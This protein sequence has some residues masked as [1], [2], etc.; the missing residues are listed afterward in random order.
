MKGYA[1]KTFLGYIV[2]HGWNNGT[3]VTLHTWDD[4][5]A[6]DVDDIIACALALSDDFSIDECLWVHSSDD[7]LVARIDILRGIPADLYGGPEAVVR[8]RAWE[9]GRCF[10]TGVAVIINE[11]EAYDTFDECGRCDGSGLVDNADDS[12]F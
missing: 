7:T 12:H 8:Q 6:D 9:C 2:V 11:P 10:G 3:P 4:L 1:M 5:R